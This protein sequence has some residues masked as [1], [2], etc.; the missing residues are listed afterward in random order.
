MLQ[1]SSFKIYKFMIKNTTIQIFWKH[2][3]YTD[4]AIPMLTNINVDFN[5]KGNL[6]LVFH[7]SMHGCNYKHWY[8]KS[9]TRQHRKQSSIFKSTWQCSWKHVCFTSDFPI[10]SLRNK[11]KIRLTVTIGSTHKTLSHARLI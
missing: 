8:Q 1:H 9:C 4:K 7:I 11:N 6:I 5:V 3:Q 2:F 10:V